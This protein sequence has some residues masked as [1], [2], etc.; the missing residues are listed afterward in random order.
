[1]LID[2]SYPDTLGTP[3]DG[4]KIS[5]INFKGSENSISVDSSAVRVAV[6]CG[7]G[8]CTGTWDWSELTV[9]GGKAAEI[10]GFSGI[11]G[12]SFK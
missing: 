5:D 10:T 11:S 8:S 1:M 3:G 4:V 9:T 12:G 6:N 2:Q 7:S